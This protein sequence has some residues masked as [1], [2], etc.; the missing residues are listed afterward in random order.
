MEAEASG[1]N[2]EA[3]EQDDIE[4]HAPGGRRAG[5]HASSA[6]ANGHRR[7][8]EDDADPDGAVCLWPLLSMQSAS[9]AF[10]L[11]T[12]AIQ[13]VS[14]SHVCLIFARSCQATGRRRVLMVRLLC[15][16]IEMARG[17]TGSMRRS[18]RMMTWIWRERMQRMG[19]HHPALQG[20]A[21]MHIDS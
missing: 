19:N 14:A 15:R 12:F 7:D 11:W 2:T 5:P 3:A 20:G 17:K 1:S 9:P 4:Q 13:H 16:I 6:A 10:W 18:A 21:F 8:G